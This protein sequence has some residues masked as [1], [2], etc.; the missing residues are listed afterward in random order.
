MRGATD[1]GG[2]GDY[3]RKPVATAGLKFRGP[4]SSRAPVAIRTPVRQPGQDSAM[5]VWNAV[6]ECSLPEEPVGRA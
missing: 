4:A 5:K 2:R 6:R 3:Q 1:R